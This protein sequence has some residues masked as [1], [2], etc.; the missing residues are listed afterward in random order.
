MN[1]EKY[2][3]MIHSVFKLYE[4]VWVEDYLVYMVFNMQWARLALSKYLLFLSFIYAAVFLF[5]S[6]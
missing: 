2:F 5:I 4:Y 6:Y 3:L 1:G